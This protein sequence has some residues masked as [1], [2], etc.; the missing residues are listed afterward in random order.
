MDRR[1]AA[2]I[3]IIDHNVDHRVSVSELARSVNLSAGR[4]SYL[5]RQVTRLSPRAYAQRR[6]LQR[7]RE[8]LD[9]TFLKINE[10]AAQVGF[11]HASSFTCNFR[12][13]F[14]YPPSRLSRKQVAPTQTAQE[15]QNDKLA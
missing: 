14:G 9:G 11:R 15:G 5:F 13:Q 2:A 4:F 6:R 7:A 12:D 3:E 1:I 10:V 8:L